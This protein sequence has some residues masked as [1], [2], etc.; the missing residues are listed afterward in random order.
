LSFPL[1]YSSP[2]G[3]EG[4]WLKKRDTSAI[5]KPRF[6][7]SVQ[8]SDSPGRRMDIYESGKEMPCSEGWHQVIEIS[9]YV[10]YRFFQ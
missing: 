8:K 10:I 1:A 7:A 9:F 6:L 3:L 5:E 4:F 2:Q